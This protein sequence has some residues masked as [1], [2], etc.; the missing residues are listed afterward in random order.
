MKEVEVIEL[1]F[2]KNFTI[3]ECSD[4]DA[5]MVGSKS[6][7]GHKF[8]L[9]FFHAGIFPT[10]GSDIMDLRN[11]YKRDQIN[12]VRETIGDY[13]ESEWKWQDE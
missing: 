13:S 1:I 2:K 9:D 12:R 5:H 8:G 3:V 4:G 11:G 6:V 7:S 10:D